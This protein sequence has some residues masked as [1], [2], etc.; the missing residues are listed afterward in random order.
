[1]PT[2]RGRFQG[3]AP[4]ELEAHPDEVPHLSSTGLDRHLGGMV[5]WFDGDRMVEAASRDLFGEIE[6]LGEVAP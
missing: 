6:R 5:R 2:C 1:M 4:C 3:R